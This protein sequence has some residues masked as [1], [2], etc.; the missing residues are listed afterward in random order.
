MAMDQLDL[1]I[2]SC[3]SIAHLSAAMGKETWVVVPAMPYYPWARPGRKSDWYP[4]VTLF[5]QKCF[6][7]WIPP[8]VEIKECLTR[9]VNKSPMVEI[10]S[11]EFY[12]IY[13]KPDTIKNNWY[14]EGTELAV[15][16][17]L[18]KKYYV[19]SVLEIGINK[20]ETAK[21]LLDNCP[22]INKYEG[23]EVTPEGA[24]SMRD[25]QRE[26]R[27]SLGNEV[28]KFVKDNPK[29][30]LFISKNG[31]K[32]FKT[33]EHYDLIFIDGNHAKEYVEYDTNL[34]MSLNPKIIAWHDYG[35]EAGVTEVLD[36]M[37]YP[38]VRVMNTRMAYLILENKK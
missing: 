14:M 18:A 33:T 36:S 38:I 37:T 9:K 32:D 7:E 30:S 19:N 22:F 24:N 15:L 21:R 2:S 11:E 12:K 28:G 4:S 10:C 23:I 5:R 8:F 6:G 26:E 31:S 35:T 3:T 25:C 29:V 20:G 16:E 17:G 27:D 1:V 34:A 13:G